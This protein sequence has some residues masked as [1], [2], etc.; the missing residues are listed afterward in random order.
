MTTHKRQKPPRPA[1]WAGRGEAAR[2]GERE[3][4]P[5]PGA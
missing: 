3:T 5:D 4:R 2:A 1:A